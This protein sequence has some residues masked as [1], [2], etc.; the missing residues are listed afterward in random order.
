MMVELTIW[1]NFLE[2]RNLTE[3]DLQENDI[4]IRNGEWLTAF[5]ETQTSLECL[6][7]ATVKCKVD[8]TDFQNFETLVARC[9][10]LKRLKLNREITLEQ[11]QRLLLRAPQLVELGTGIYN[12]SLSWGR[13]QELQVALVRCKNLRSLSGLW[14]V[15]PGCLPTLYPTCLQ[16]TTLDLSN[17]LIGSGDFTKLINFCKKLQRLLVGYLLIE[18]LSQVCSLLFDNTCV[19]FLTDMKNR[20]LS[21]KDAFA[22]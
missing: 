3:L 10:N 20:L 17:V 21:S 2:H 12:Q 6:N 5:P 1:C 16:L 15:V 14:D 11:L 19:G 22:L 7:F 18:V 4:H 9:P 8:E 13:L